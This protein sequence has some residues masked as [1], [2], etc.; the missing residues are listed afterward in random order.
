M[1][2]GAASRSIANVL[3]LVA[4][5]WLVRAEKRAAS[6][7]SDALLLAE[8]ASDVH[9]ALAATPSA[10][11]P[12]LTTDHLWDQTEA[13]YFLGVSPR[14][15]RESSCPKVLLPGAGEKGQPVV[16]YDPHEVTRWV[17]GWRTTTRRPER[18]A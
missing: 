18:V 4:D 16:R 14:Y 15:L 7:P 2:A 11:R 12:L 1:S 10:D 9:V 3:A 5:A 6:K 13:A 8:M 17:D